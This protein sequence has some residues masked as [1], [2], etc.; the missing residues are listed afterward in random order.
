MTSAKFSFAFYVFINSSSCEK[1][2]YLGRN[3]LY[4]SKKRPKSNL[5]VF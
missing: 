2:P 3:L 5:E 1:H 4:L